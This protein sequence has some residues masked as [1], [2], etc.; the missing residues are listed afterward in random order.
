MG[1]IIGLVGFPNAGKSTLFNALTGGEVPAEAYPFCTIQPHEGVVF[2]K[3]ERL[4]L[5]KEVL[6]PEEVRY[7][8]ITILDVAGLIRG[9]HKGEGLG[10]AFLSHLRPVDGILQVIRLFHHPQVGHPEGNLDPLRDYEVIRLELSKKDEEILL[11]RIEKA[12]KLVAVGEKE[13]R[14]SL[15]KLESYLQNLQENPLHPVFQVDRERFPDL[16]ILALKPEVVLANVDETG[17]REVVEK[18]K[19]TIPS[20]VIPLNASWEESLQELDEKEQE[21]YRR[22]LQPPG[23]TKEELL[24]AL[25][26]VGKRHLFFTF[27]HGIVQ[28]WLIPE[29][30]PAKKAAGMIHQDM[31]K[32]FIKAEVIHWEDFALVK[33]LHIL[34]DQG[35]IHA[36]GKDYILQDGDLVTFLFHPGGS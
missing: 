2:L 25:L 17:N 34:K 5:L 23:A 12:K 7:P 3:D 33:D 8:T 14:K 13:A 19:K 10:N 18:L 21:E 11:R 24:K 27:S 35:K 31:E 22:E 1:F 30:T 26:R 16:E 28:G 36:Q 20:P 32:G 4:T 6:K 29:G 9:S 15:E